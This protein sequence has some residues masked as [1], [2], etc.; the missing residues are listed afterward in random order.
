MAVLHYGADSSV[1]LEFADGVDPDLCGT[2]RAGR[3]ATRR[4]RL[5]LRSQQPLE[6]PPL[7]KT[8]TPGDRVVLVLDH[9]LPQAAGVT[10]AVIRLL[11][12]AGVEPD[13][14]SIL[15]SEAA[16]RGGAENP[17]SLLDKAWRRGLPPSPT[18][19]ATATI[20][21]TWRP[22]MRASRSS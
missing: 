3:W 17:C 15:R 8:A 11:V 12:A 18:I 13:G 16:A 7:A 19:P 4:P 21:P 2:P 20:W 9:A 14:I 10:A 5:P 6:Y 22:T 1:R